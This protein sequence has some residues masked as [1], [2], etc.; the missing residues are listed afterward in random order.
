MIQNNNTTKH[1]MSTTNLPRWTVPPEFTPKPGPP[2]EGGRPW[3]R[4][5]EE[6]AFSRPWLR[7]RNVDHADGTLGRRTERVEPLRMPGF[8]KRYDCATAQPE[9]RRR[10]QANHQFRFH[11][12]VSRHHSYFSICSIQIEAA[13]TGPV[14]VTAQQERGSKVA[15]G[16]R[17]PSSGRGCDR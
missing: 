2:D 17:S 5:L 7:A 13:D 10:E 15:S 11:G 14:T 1:D 6:M 4:L 9:C 12:S 8:L 3:G 16:V